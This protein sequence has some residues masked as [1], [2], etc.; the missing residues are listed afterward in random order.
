MEVNIMAKINSEKKKAKSKGWKP[1]SAKS[2]AKGSQ[3]NKKRKP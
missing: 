1:R 3:K 2:N